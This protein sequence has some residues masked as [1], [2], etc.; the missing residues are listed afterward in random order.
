MFKRVLLSLAFLA[1]PFVVRAEEYLENSVVLAGAD[2]GGQDFG[3]L[4]NVTD[5]E[6]DSLVLYLENDS[7][8]DGAK[9][10]KKS[11]VAKGSNGDPYF[12]LVSA[13]DNH[14]VKG[15]DRDIILGMV[16]KD[17]PTNL[18]SGLMLMY[19]NISNFFLHP[20][21]LLLI[22][23]ILVL[24]VVTVI[25]GF[26]KFKKDDFIAVKKYAAFAGI[27]VILVTYLAALM[28]EDFIGFTV[29]K[30]YMMGVVY[31]ALSIIVGFA[32]GSIFSKFYFENKILP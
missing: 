21:L 10:N 11:D 29:Y 25:L 23:V 9:E 12:D 3:N 20:L 30:K 31:L 7:V 24:L 14:K 32:L 15:M 26:T 13:L 16:V 4:V 8:V 22:F 2:S 5:E 1:S 17:T 19:S 6:I 28:F 27:E 18:L